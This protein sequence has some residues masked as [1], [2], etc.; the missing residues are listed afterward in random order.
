MN[1]MIADEMGI[2]RGELPQNLFR[3]AYQLERLG[4]VGSNPEAG[5]WPTDARA[6]APLA[7]RPSY[8]VSRL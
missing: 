4:T 3:S 2:P 7:V 8:P 6:V 5:P 1:N